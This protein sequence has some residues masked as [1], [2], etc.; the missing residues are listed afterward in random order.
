M[1]A[2]IPRAISAR[3]FAPARVPKDIINVLNAA[4]RRRANARRAALLV[5]RGLRYRAAARPSST[6]RKSASEM[7]KWEKAW[8]G[9]LVWSALLKLGAHGE[10]R[11]LIIG[12]THSPAE[13]RRQHDIQ[14]TAEF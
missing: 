7:A 8:S 11:Y 5:E 12:L 4:I 13:H 1:T 14:L 9:T 3:G 2:W 6:G 10:F